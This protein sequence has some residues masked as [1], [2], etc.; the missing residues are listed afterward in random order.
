MNIFKV[1]ASGKKAMH[2]EYTSAIVSWFLNP[3]MEHGLGFSFLATFIEELY[4]KNL[5]LDKICPEFKDIHGKLVSR[6]RT[7]SENDLDVDCWLEEY[8]DDAYID[9][10]LQIGSW[11]LSIENK[12]YN[13]SAKKIQLVKQY[14]GLK[15][16]SDKYFSAKYGKP[17]FGIIFLVPTDGEV[18]HPNVEEEFNALNVE[19][20]DFRTIVTWQKTMDQSGVEQYPS[21]CNVIERVLEKEAKGISDPIPEYTRHTLKALNRFIITDFSG[22]EYQKKP[23]TSGQNPLTYDRRDINK[24]KQDNKGFVGVQFGLSGLLQMKV[25]ELKSYNFQYSKSDM[26]NK[27]NWIPIDTFKKIISWMLDGNVPDIVWD[28]KKLSSEILYKIAKDFKDKV[29][30]GIKGGE[31][32]LRGM[33]SSQIRDKSWSI[34][35]KKGSTSWITGSTY[36]DILDDKEVF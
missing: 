26:K 12:I 1:F 36:C 10:V 11:V 24:L 13:D 22:Y 34:S 3:R 23:S 17:R 32:A 5:E 28:A 30:I 2:E 15:K 20:G 8:V 29:F 18:L 9:V 4:S 7:D 14:A 6:L 33:D 25:N 27:R 35:S 31:K 21:I 16:N 19:E